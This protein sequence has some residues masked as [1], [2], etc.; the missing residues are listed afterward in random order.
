MQMR[1]KKKFTKKFIQ[2]PKPNMIKI[3][4]I[5]YKN[6]VNIPNKQKKHFRN[7]LP[8]L[9]NHYQPFLFLDKMFMIPSKNRTLKVQLLKYQQFYQNYGKIW[10]RKK[11]RN[12]FKNLNKNK[13]NMISNT[14]SIFQIPKKVTPQK[15]LQ[16]LFLFINKK[17]NFL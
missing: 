13:N 16:H 9:K 5:I 4:M 3:K 11:N 8:P 2:N 6:M 14:N 10:I 7:N 1:N 17:F 15:N 12:I